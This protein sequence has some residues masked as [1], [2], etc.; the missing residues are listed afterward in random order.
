VASSVPA[1]RAQAL[2]RSPRL[3][4]APG[5]DNGLDALRASAM[6]WMTL[7]HFCWDLNLFGWVQL[8]MLKD[9]VWWLQR[10]AIVTLFVACAGAAQALAMAQG[11]TWA[12]F[13]RRWAQVAGCALLVSAASW[14]MFPRTYIHFGVLHGLAVMLLLV[15]L[16]AP[17]FE[18][19][20][21]LPWALAALALL[22]AHAGGPSAVLGE[23][24]AQWFNSRWLNGL[25]FIDRKP[26]TEDFVPVL[27]WLAAMCGGYA[28]GRLWARRIRGP[29]GGPIEPTADEFPRNV[30]LRSWLR[31]APL[32]R[33]SLSYY[34]LHQPV[35]LG[36]LALI[37]GGLPGMAR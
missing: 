24:W 2:E 18:R 10:T 5:R 37:N 26:V 12:R 22:A 9:P 32:G 29:Q 33:W 28:L 27:P 17:A 25:G 31:L 13:W 34:M 6:L 15:R 7:Y 4:S 16:L 11:Q 20:P 3:A 23:Q 35:M 19:C 1:A 21:V 36:V 14:W 8:Q 30:A